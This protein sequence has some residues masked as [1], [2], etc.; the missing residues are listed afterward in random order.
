[1]IRLAVS[2]KDQ[3]EG[4]YLTLSHCW[5]QREFLKL[6]RDN[7]MDLRS[8]FPTSSLPRTFQEAVQ[9]ARRLGVRYIWID[10]LCIIQGDE[11]DWYQESMQM[12]KVYANAI[13]NIAATASRDDTEGLFRDRNPARMHR[14]ECEVAFNSV[15]ESHHRLFTVVQT[16]WWGSLLND[17]PL[18]LR[19]WVMQERLLARRVIHFGEEEVVWVRNLVQDF[20]Y[21]LVE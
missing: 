19:A 1:M 9:V 10:S 18:N 4:S 7:M 20:Q 16:H 21:R 11:A 6:T 15:G 14:V 13:C 8:G 12:G 17:Q 3:F 2:S 5:G